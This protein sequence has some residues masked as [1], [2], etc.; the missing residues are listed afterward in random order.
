MASKL[1]YILKIPLK[2]SGKTKVTNT[3]YRHDIEGKKKALK[4]F[5]KVI[6]QYFSANNTSS[7]LL[8]FP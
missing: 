8:L 7:I 6:I 4:Y 2:H 5:F 3:S 1:N